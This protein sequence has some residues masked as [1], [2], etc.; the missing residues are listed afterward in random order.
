M[1]MPI[2]GRRLPP[3]FAKALNTD[4][5]AET[6]EAANANV[7]EYYETTYQLA[8]E[9]Q[10][11][12]VLQRTAVAKRSYGDQT[13]IRKFT[14]LEAMSL[15]ATGQYKKADTLL[16]AYI[17]ENPSD[18][19]RP[20]VDAIL[21]NVNTQK[22]ADTLKTTDTTKAGSLNPVLA[23]TADSSKTT[24]LSTADTGTVKK[25]IVPEQYTYVPKEAH[26]CV[27]L[28]GKPDAKTAGFR[29]GLTDFTTMKFSML[30]VNSGQEMLNADQSM[31]VTK[32]FGNAAQAKAFMNTAKNE[33]LLFREMEK[34]SYQYFIISEKNFLRMKAEKKTDNYLPF[35]RKNYK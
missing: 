9:R 7:S 1:A 22:A 4:I 18:S 25:I 16:Q 34:G 2:Y 23:G 24:G 5:K 31:V 12:N 30:S 3:S 28:F 20:W 27:F 15:A 19:L 14:L 10:Y 32:T 11:E 29:S 17:K 13:Y 6:T 26:Y 33:N 8:I 35:Y 21:K